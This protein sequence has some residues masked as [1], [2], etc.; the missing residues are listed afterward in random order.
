MENIKKFR[1]YSRGRIV[2]AVVLGAITKPILDNGASRPPKC[3]S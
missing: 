3:L 1:G 2:I